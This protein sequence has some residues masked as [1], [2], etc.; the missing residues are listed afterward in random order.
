MKQNSRKKL[1][2]GIGVA[3][4][5]AFAVSAGFAQGKAETGKSK[6]VSYVSSET[7]TFQDIRLGVT[8]AMLWATAI[9]DGMEHL[10]S[11]RRATMLECIHTQTMCGWSFS[12]AL[13]YIRMTRAR[14]E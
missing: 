11:S 1:L 7:A 14:S 13:I 4:A 5:I 6:E 2:I 12:K 3:A 10:P 9:M 8:M